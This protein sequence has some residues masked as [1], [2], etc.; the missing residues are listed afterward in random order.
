[1]LKVG[2]GRIDI[3]PQEHVE[4]GG[5]GNG[6]HRVSTHVLDTLFASCVAITDEQDNTLLLIQKLSRP[7]EEVFD[8]SQPWNRDRYNRMIQEL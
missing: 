4:L 7:A 3:M 2:F 1:M 8:L 6:P 5:Y